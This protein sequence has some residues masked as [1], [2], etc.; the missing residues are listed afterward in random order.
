MEMANPTQAI[1]VSFSEYVRKRRIESNAHIENGI[2]DYAYGL[3]YT[4]RQKINAIPGALKLCKSL[5]N[6]WIPAEKQRLNTHC[7][8]VGPS[9][10]PDIYEQA[11]YCAKM[12]GIGMPTVFIDPDINTINAYAFAA[13]D[14]APMIVLTSQLLERFSSGEV[15]TTIG[16]ECGHIHNNHSIYQVPAMLIFGMFDNDFFPGLRQLLA[17]VT[18]PL[19]FTLNAWNRAAEITC[20][21]AGIICADNLNDAITSQAKFLYGGI[22][23]RNDVNIEEILKQYEDIRKTPVRLLE[24]GDTHPLPVKRILAAKEFINSE[25]LYGWRADF[26]KNGMVLI[27][28]QE[29]DARCEKYINVLGNKQEGKK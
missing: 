7:L 23:A 21:R 3:D 15:K 1:N 11:K 14:N 17:L 25:V 26:K 28:K 20:D 24:L 8:K 12:L 4:L 6:T 19:R 13:D 16:H 22:M 18:M 27:N 9:Q 29:L 5:L 10:Y 2:P